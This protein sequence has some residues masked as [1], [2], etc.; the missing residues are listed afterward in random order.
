MTEIMSELEFNI[1][2]ELELATTEETNLAHQF[3]LFEHATNSIFEKEEK[4]EAITSE[5]N[6]I[7]QK[8]KHENG[9]KF[10]YNYLV[11]KRNDL[12]MREKHLDE[13]YILITEKEQEFQIINERIEELHLKEA[14]FLER[15]NKLNSQEAK[16]I[17]QK[18][19]LKKMEENIKKDQQSFFKKQYEMEIEEINRL[20]QNEYSCPISKEIMQNPVIT[21]DGFFY[22]KKLIKNWLKQN[23]SSPMT[24]EPIE[25]KNNS[26]YFDDHPEYIVIPSKKMECTIQTII[27]RKK[28][29]LLKL[30]NLDG[31]LDSNT[32]IDTEVINPN[33][34]ESQEYEEERKF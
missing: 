30:S 28:K 26:I 24:R 27:A 5:L 16:I 13:R 9:P 29:L 4:L 18:E 25:K 23:D 8:F 6:H 11:S 7:L 32:N 33:I 17:Q 1:Q 2:N 34:R 20:L 10:A 14:E 31:V 19:R 22:E 15:K 21:T 12:D 3:F